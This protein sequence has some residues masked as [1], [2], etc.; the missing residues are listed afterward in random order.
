MNFVQSAKWA[1]KAQQ[2]LPATFITV[3]L[4]P[5]TK[6]MTLFLLRTPHRVLRRQYA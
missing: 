1:H 2:R 5:E 3:P 6:P 4:T